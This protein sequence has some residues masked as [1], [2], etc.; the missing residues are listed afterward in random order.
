MSIK[1]RII[2]SLFIL[3]LGGLFIV[4][5][6]KKYQLNKIQ[7]ISEIY[8]S[9][10]ERL[11][12]DSTFFSLKSAEYFKH[13][14]KKNIYGTLVSFMLANK[15][16]TN[17]NFPKA[18]RSLQ[19]KT[20]YSDKIIK[21]LCSLRLARIQLHQGK[22]DKFITTLNHININ[23]F[24]WSAIIADLQGNAMIEKGNVNQALRF[25]HE[26]MKD[27]TLPFMR[28]LIKMKIKYFSL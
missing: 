19:L 22:I 1:Y 26:A 11:N 5:S 20:C 7:N 23:S 17:N 21:T 28:Y 9:H 16:I 12:Q 4:M 10:I 25:W 3:I 13:E 14:N 8:Q 24:S 27:S 18:A 6:W 2:L 15:Y